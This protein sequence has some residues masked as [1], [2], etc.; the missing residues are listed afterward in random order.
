MFRKKAQT[1]AMSIVII[2]GIIISLVSVAY[3]WG[4]PLIEKRSTIAEFTSIENFILELNDKIIDIANSGSG[5]HVIEIPFGTIKAIEYKQDDPNSNTLIFEHTIAQPIV[6]NA[7]IPI[8][9]NNLQEVATYGEA[10]PRMISMSVYPHD[11][12]YIMNM[13][14]HYRELDTNTLPR[15]GFL[16]KLVPVSDFGRKTITLSFGGN[17]VIPGGAA[18]NG[19]LVVTNI[20]V[21]LV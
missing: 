5:R 17:V 16:I 14:L 9:T 6:L 3:I 7:T 11:T 18:N 19:D 20:D 1:Q 4:K 15:K 13:K 12:A 10:Q 21:E 2:T 8:K